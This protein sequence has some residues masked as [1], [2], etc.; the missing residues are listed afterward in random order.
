MQV[1]IFENCKI[2]LKGNI[3]L[4]CKNLCEALFLIQQQ[5]GTDSY[6]KENE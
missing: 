4:L 1:L 6:K 3:K 2:E 5:I